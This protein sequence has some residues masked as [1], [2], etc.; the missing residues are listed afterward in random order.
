MRLDSHQ[1]FWRYNPAEHVRM[2]GQMVTFD[3]KTGEAMLQ[4]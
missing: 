1:H 4:K 3:I 2:T